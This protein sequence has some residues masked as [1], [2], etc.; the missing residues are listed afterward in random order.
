MISAPR[1]SFFEELPPGV[2]LVNW[3]P[4]FSSRS[5]RSL[6]EN[7]RRFDYC[8]LLRLRSFQARHPEFKSSDDDIYW[9]LS[10]LLCS[11]KISRIR[12]FLVYFI[13]ICFFR[14]L[15]LIRFRQMQR[16]EMSKTETI[17][18]VEAMIVTVSMLMPSE[19]LLVCGYLHV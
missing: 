6:D 18:Q 11:S 15:S 3:E 1:S 16:R 7:L 14:F 12:N 8:Y 5:W 10:E 4:Q 19:S 17:M 2:R 13:S 9:L